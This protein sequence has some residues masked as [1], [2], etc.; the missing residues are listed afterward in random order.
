M[1]HQLWTEISKNWLMYQT[2]LIPSLLVSCYCRSQVLSFLQSYFNGVWSFRSPSTYFLFLALRKFREVIVG[3]R[4]HWQNL[5]NII[6]KLYEMIE[7]LWS[8]LTLEQNSY[9]IW[10]PAGTPILVLS[11]LV[12]SELA[13][14]YRQKVKSKN[15]F[16][17]VSN[18]TTKFLSVLLPF[19]TAWSLSN[20]HIPFWQLPY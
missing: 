20:L 2:H 5:Q 9:W 4:S 15:Y 8:N 10:L 11:T 18:S 1:F 19:W 12:Y 17:Q 16:A 14:D 6:Q 7:I 3:E 13:L